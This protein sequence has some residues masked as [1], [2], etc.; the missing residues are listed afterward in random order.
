MQLISD[1]GLLT[2][3]VR[4]FRRPIN[5]IKRSNLSLIVD[6]PILMEALG[7]SGQNSRKS[8]DYFISRLSEK[9]VKFFYFNKSID[10]VR[11]SITGMRNLPVHERY[12]PTH[13]AMQNGEIDDPYVNSVFNNTNTLLH[14]IGIQRLPS[15]LESRRNNDHY[16]RR[17]N[18][19]KLTN[20][21]ESVYH[22]QNNSYF[23]AKHDAEAVASIMRLRG[24]EFATSDIF[25]CQFAFLSRNSAFRDTAR[26]FCMRG[27]V[28]SADVD[29]MLAP[30]EVGP[31]IDIRELASALWF[32]MGSD[33]NESQSRL[34]LMSS[35]ER[36]L[37]LNR[38][39]VGKVS[40]AINKLG[41]GR[42]VDSSD[43]VRKARVALMHPGSSRYLQDYV[44]GA[45]GAIDYDDIL[46]LQKQFEED[47]IEKGIEKK[48]VHYK[49]EI[50][51]LEGQL[52][53][54]VESVQSTNYKYKLHIDDGIEENE[55]LKKLIDKKEDE[56]NQS[57]L[58]DIEM[59]RHLG[60]N[61]G[62]YPLDIRR[63]NAVYH[64]S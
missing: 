51:S 46:R 18:L 11:R 55:K 61:I 62:V 25:T 44:R 26:A 50:K 23:R 43:A 27:A 48:A 63:T 54:A 53:V 9:G 8:I 19:D 49:N 14:E 56:L 39:V 3:L 22:S 41:L 36:V 31:V 57:K 16:F 40:T 38:R 10:E 24:G 17:L 28:T 21:L 20:D 33:N 6:S 12:G 58:H 4:E 1:V 30:E 64:A 47:Q 34:S 13:A 5:E 2:E 52:I 45:Q 37:R 15:N 7:I 29:V 60:S 59:A 32:R 42:T 35:C